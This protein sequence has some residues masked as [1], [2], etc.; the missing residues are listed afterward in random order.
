M[1]N[2]YAFLLIILTFC[3]IKTN[4]QVDR[5]LIEKR[6]DTVFKKYLTTKG[7][8]CA[9]GVV[10]DGKVIIAKGYG[11]ANLEYRIPINSASIFDIASLSKEFTG[12]VV[13][14]LIQQGKISVEDDI[15]KYLPDVPDFGKVITINNLLHHTSGLRDWPE[16]LNMAGWRYEEEASFEDIMKMV[17][18]QKEL[19][20]VPGS[21]YQYSNTGSNLLAA[22]IE[23]VS[24]K[25]F[26]Q[27]TDSVIFK[28]MGMLNTHFLDDKNSIVPNLAYSYEGH[29]DKFT[30]VQ[31]V[32]TAYGSSSLYTSVD[33]L[34]KWMINFAQQLALKNPVYVRMTDASLLN[35]GSKNNYGFGLV[36]GMDR[37]LKIINHT[38]G[39]AAY[40]TI[41]QFYPDENLAIIILCNASDGKVYDEYVK[42]A[43]DIFL[44]DKFKTQPM[45][46]E[47]KLPAVKVDSVLLKKY[48]GNYKWNHGVIAITT[49][50]AELMFQYIGEDIYPT[51][52]LSD[53]SFYL[54]IAKHT[55]TFLKPVD[56]VSNSLKFRDITGTRFVTYNPKITELVEFVGIYQ[57]YELES[58]FKIELNNSKLMFG[59][60]R[61]G[62]FELNPF[63]K[64]EFSS[65]KNKIVFFRD[66]NNKVTGFK[67]TGN[68]VRN[69]KFDKKE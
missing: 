18:N 11:M 26:R 22:I 59:N 48:A 47:S 42:G 8:G 3:T 5:N 56:G 32:L 6:I 60:F 43:A 30:K 63:I 40:N 61:L 52:A 69:L 57:S 29:D 46:A 21:E 25:T 53:T 39:W 49:K 50:G 14:T 24:G 65:D 4:A 64:D 35:N 34:T 62:D 2:N 10:K 58:R 38:G 23:K 31:N 28:S 15:H 41:V 54:A 45:P 66:A 13:S 68:R 33:D 1:K 16:V 7:P 20:F 44:K 36:T 17:K 19:D 37:G 12:L 51:K 9:V 55:V 27:Y 67:Y